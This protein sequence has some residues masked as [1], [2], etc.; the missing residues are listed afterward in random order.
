M[1]PILEYLCLYCWKFTEG[2]H[3][4][5]YEGFGITEIQYLPESTEN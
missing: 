1:E 5:F 4:D 3:S 2:I